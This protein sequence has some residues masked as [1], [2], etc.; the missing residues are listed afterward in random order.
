MPVTDAFNT[1]IFGLVSLTK[2]VNKLPTTPTRIG[3]LGIFEEQGITTTTVMIDEVNGRVALVPETRRGAPG[4]PVTP[5]T[6]T[7]RSIA[8]GHIQTD[9]HIKADDVQNIRAFGSETAEEVLAQKVNDRLAAMKRYTDVTREYRRVHALHGNILDADGATS[10]CNLFTEFGVSEVT[11]DF[12]LDTATTNVRETCMTV[13]R[14]IDDAVGNSAVITAYRAICGETWFDKFTAHDHVK[15]TYANWEAA[16]DLRADL[17]KGF[18]FGGI[19]WEAYRATVS[20]V[21]FVHDDQARVFPIGTGLYA[22]Y[23]A[24]A[25]Y[26][27][28]VNTVGLPSYARQ[29]ATPDGKGYN[30]EVQ[31]N[32][33]ALAFFPA[34]LIKCTRS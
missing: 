19:T 10:L 12:V 13:L 15:E 16:V 32:P 30:L 25:D 2:A 23:F 7:A 33:L 9:D 17:R 31:S 24:P 6:R 34:A 27:E 21:D 3:D 8:V 4:T 5:A 14:A 18:M 28:T 29:W 22:E 20:G 1:D 11:V 26:N